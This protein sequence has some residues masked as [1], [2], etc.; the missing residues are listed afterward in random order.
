MNKLLEGEIR[1]GIK[2][3]PNID[4][5]S[6]E[7]I[8]SALR[9]LY[10][11][12]KSYIA[13]QEAFYSWQQLKGERL[14]EFSLALLGL[15]DRLRQQSSHAISNADV[16]VRDQFI[17]GVLDNALRRELKQLVGA[18]LLQHYWKCEGKPSAGKARECQVVRSICSSSKGTSIGVQGNT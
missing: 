16:V 8:I 14:Q 6:P 13:L 18:S 17:E 4:R 12:T 3:R 9:E 2:Y 5:N 11:C 15:F 7:R 1:D 10:G